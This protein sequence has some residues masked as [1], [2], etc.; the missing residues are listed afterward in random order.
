[1]SNSPMVVAPPPFFVSLSMI[2][3]IVGMGVVMDGERG[4]LLYGRNDYSADCG[5]FG[6]LATSRSSC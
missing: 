4:Q 1:V 5:N 3:V 6:S 2:F